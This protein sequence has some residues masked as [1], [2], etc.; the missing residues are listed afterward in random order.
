MLVTPSLQNCHSFCIH[1]SSKSTITASIIDK[2][3]EDLLSQ[4]VD[5][6][7]EPLSFGMVPERQLS[8]IL[9]F[10]SAQRNDAC[11][12]DFHCYSFCLHR[13]NFK[14]QQQRQQYSTTDIRM[15]ALQLKDMQRILQL[16]AYPDSYAKYL[17]QLIESDR[18][19]LGAYHREQGLI[20]TAMIHLDDLS[21]GGLAVHSSFRRQ[22]IALALSQHTIEQ[23]FK[24]GYSYVSSNV[25]VDNTA[26][27]RLLK[28]L[29][30]EKTNGAYYWL[31]T[32]IAT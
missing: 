8:L 30:F 4:F 10:W 20:G 16:N 9:R 17:A 5:W 12:I 6:T 15:A 26:P 13:L 19:S 22:G 31:S 28:K 11:S 24:Q 23:H 7:L 32:A 27:Q 1:A 14:Q 18:V 25:S 2:E 21:F 29:G 3:F